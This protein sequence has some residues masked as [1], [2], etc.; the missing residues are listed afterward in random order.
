MSLAQAFYLFI[1]PVALAAGGWTVALLHLRHSQK[2][3]K[4]KHSH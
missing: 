1:L 4:P 2:T 3:N